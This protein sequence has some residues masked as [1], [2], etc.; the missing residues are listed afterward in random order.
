[1]CEDMPA[2]ARL[3]LSV[4]YF[5][6][7]CFKFPPC[8]KTCSVL[9]GCCL[10]FVTVKRNAQNFYPSRAPAGICQAA[11]YCFYCREWCPPLPS[12]TNFPV[13]RPVGCF[14]A[15]AQH[16]SLRDVLLRSATLCE[17]LPNVV[18]LRLSIFY[19]REWCAKVS[20]SGKACPTFPGCHSSFLL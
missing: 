7:W 11:T 13:E 3:L 19:C 15:A 10:L 12:L 14:Q 20:P 1:M 6:E 9:P 8:R 5:G 4:F 18:M 2:A 17:D 16:F